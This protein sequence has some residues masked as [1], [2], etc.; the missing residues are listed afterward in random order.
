MLL[1][2]LGLYAQG[3]PLVR[4]L[5]VYHCLLYG[6]LMPF[7]KYN[8]L[9]KLTVH[10]VQAYHIALKQNLSAFPL[11]IIGFTNLFFFSFLLIQLAECVEIGLPGLI[12]LIL[13][14]QVSL[15]L[16]NYQIKLLRLYSTYLFYLFV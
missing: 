15:V 13:L 11:S 16:N 3:F 7:T 2:G 9:Y 4:L 6:L 8:W 5:T 12:I 10:H 1:V 14:S